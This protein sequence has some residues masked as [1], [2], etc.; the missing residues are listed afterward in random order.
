MDIV[1]NY[2][3][4]FVLRLF[5]IGMMIFELGMVFLSSVLLRI[6]VFDGYYW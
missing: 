3:C 1:V 2:V 5:V 4:R 6:V